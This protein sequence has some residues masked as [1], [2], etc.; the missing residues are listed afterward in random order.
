M[1]KFFKFFVE[2]IAA[3]LVVGWLIGKYPELIESVIPVL[4]LMIFWHLTW[5]Y[6]LKPAAVKANAARILGGVGRMAWILVFVAGGLVSVLYWYGIKAGLSELAALHAESLSPSTVAQTSPTAET[7][8]IGDPI[9]HLS[10]LGWTVKH[11]GDQILFEVANKTVPDMIESARYFKEL[12][13]PFYLH[14]QT[15]PSLSGL[16]YLSG[17]SGCEQI[18][19]SAS[20]LPDI[21]EL[22]GFRDLKRLLISQVPLNTR[23]DMDAS[24]LATLTNLE[25][26][27]LN[28]SRFTN[29][30]P[31][32]GMTHLS[33]LSI[34]GTLIR[35][36]SPVRSL[37]GL[38]SV[39]VRDSHVT[40]LAPLAASRGLE[41]LTVDGKQVP[42]VGALSSAKG[43]RKLVLIDQNAVDF[44]PIEALSHL[45]SIFIW[46]PP[47]INLS[48]V[49]KLP[50]LRSLQ[51]SSFGVPAASGSQIVDASAICATGELDALTIGSVQLDSL[52]FVT[53][54][55][56]LTELNLSGMRIRSI[57]E[58]SGM[59]LL[60]KISLVDVPVV[61]ISPLLTLA[62]L[63]SVT[64]LRVPARAD[65]ISE[66]ERRGV[67]VSNP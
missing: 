15:V 51:I 7:P 30:E 66:L 25:T 65:V 53:G 57:A 59:H 33:A 16:H 6:G 60:R 58:L 26:L 11:D 32:Q 13:G 9:S 46:G 2:I 22:A 41:E 40:D 47:V 54:C 27:L 42:T 5:E 24:P 8:P 34:G 36:L 19:I 23:T 49:R 55:T 20:D 61:E 28:S 4:A 3:A 52:D 12:R 50:K 18:E 62:N 29:L 14:F 43:L 63:E 38:K 44:S 67:K 35:D 45:E 56:K 1:G 48:F 21:S 64:L 37:T 31:V 39:D 17:V 10:Q